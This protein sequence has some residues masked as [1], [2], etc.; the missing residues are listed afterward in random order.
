M[1]EPQ[2]G[3]A[4]VLIE[5]GVL[6]VDHRLHQDLGHLLEGDDRTALLRQLADE[7]STLTID[8]GHELRVVLFESAHVGHLRALNHGD[9]ESDA[10]EHADASGDRDTAKPSL[11]NAVLLSRTGRHR[12][13]PAE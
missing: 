2:V 4:L 9:E 7:L 6:G 11:P 1:V 8:A 12:L 10:E 3:D 5:G 13:D